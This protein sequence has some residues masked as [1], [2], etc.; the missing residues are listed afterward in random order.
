M[1]ALSAK[2]LGTAS[3]D[4]PK[5]EKNA[6]ALKKINDAWKGNSVSAATTAALDIGML[7]AGCMLSYDKAKDILAEHIKANPGTRPALWYRYDA[8]HLPVGTFP[9]HYR[10]GQL[11]E[12]RLRTGSTG[13]ACGGDRRTVRVWPPNGLD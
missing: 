2:D 10:D 7:V 3:A 1:A 11:P 5:N 12:P 8:P 9:G 6:L 13:H 4:K